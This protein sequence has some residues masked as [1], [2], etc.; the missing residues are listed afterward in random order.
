[1]VME[2]SFSTMFFHDHPLDQIF[3]ATV[4]SGADTLEFWPETPD[5]WL[6][7]L[8]MDRLSG[9]MEKYRFRSRISVHAPVLD[10]NPCSINPDVAKVSIAWIERSI[11]LAEQ[12]GAVVCTIHPGRR[13]SK[14]PPSPE[15]YLRLD[16]ML[17]QIA[18]VAQGSKVA[19]SIEN[20]EPQVNALLTTPEE[21]FQ[22][23][24]QRPWLSFTLD[25]CHVSS[26]GVSRLAEFLEVMPDRIV[27]IH[28]SGAEK[29]VMHLPS[30]GNPWAGEA[31]NAMMDAGYDGL[32]T[33]EINDLSC[34]GSL[35]YE[36]KVGIITRDVQYVREQKNT[37]P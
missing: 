28:L 20:M 37:G 22:I 25:A 10:L 19:V 21:V 29:G 9:V 1:M 8:P 18:P 36:E 4:R 24:E 16:H 7:G 27:N 17:D 30:R 31:L 13:T 33:L 14:R 6:S 26:Q 15:D 35:S 5:W 32:V 34:T 23:L 12:I 2:I 3:A 11:R